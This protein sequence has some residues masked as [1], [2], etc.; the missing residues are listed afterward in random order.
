MMNPDS[1]LEYIKKIMHP[2]SFLI[3]ST[4]ERDFHRGF[5]CMKSGKREHIREWNTIELKTYVESM[6]F[7][8]QEHF[9]VNFISTSILNPRSFIYKNKVKKT[10]GTTKTTQVLLCRLK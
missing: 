10:R 8:V 5:D 2:G 1:L 7:Y 9:M 3:I 4:P 6:G